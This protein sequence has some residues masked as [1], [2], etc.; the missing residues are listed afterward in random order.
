MQLNIG[1]NIKRFRKERNITQ[2]ELSEI[3]GVSFQSVSRW[4]NGTCYPDLEL[5]PTI[6]N[7]FGI[8]VDRLLGVNKV[9]EQENV[10][11]I[12]DEFQKAISVGN[13]DKCIEIARQG[14]AEYPNNYELLNTLMY[15]LFLAGNEDGNIPDRKENMLK[16]DAEI[17]AL[18]ERIVKYCPDQNI[19]LEAM[20]R[21]AFNHCIMGRKK[22]GRAI[23]EQL[24]PQDFCKESQMWWGLEEDERLPFVRD[25]IRK[26]YFA[27]ESGIYLL[28]RYK[29]LPDDE[30]VRV[31]EKELELAEL[32]YD[33]NVPVASW[34]QANAHCFYAGLLAKTRNADKAFAELE[35]AANH[36]IAFDNRPEA[37]EIGSV[38]FGTNTTHRYEF[39]TADSRPLC[40]I[41]RDKW[42][43][44]EDF[45]TIRDDK[46]F[47]AV[48][49][50]IKKY[51]SD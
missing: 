22:T 12:L 37:E 10:K 18:G 33:G 48:L 6:S 24:P 34:G 43:A 20:S 44:S 19:R 9:I 47:I 16:Y 29:L 32:M 46:R 14:V 40:E 11:K 42:L 28:S 27:L 1:E 17:T 7:F 5:L 8:T 15:A 38:L 41:L 26:G 13:I 49:D 36:A 31:L 21:L 4:E 39:D 30:L 23:Y 50:K 35:K 25:K 3:L 2:E 45:D 51:C